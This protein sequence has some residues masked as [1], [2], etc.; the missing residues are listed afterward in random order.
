MDMEH[1]HEYVATLLVRVV[2]TLAHVLLR[3]P[4]EPPPPP[5]PP[6]PPS[7]PPEATVPIACAELPRDLIYAI[8]IQQPIDTRAGEVCQAWLEAARAFKLSL[9]L[10]A[11]GMYL[12]ECSGIRT[13]AAMCMPR[14]S[15]HAV[16]SHSSHIPLVSGNFHPTNANIE[17]FDF[18]CGQWRPFEEEGIASPPLTRLGPGQ[19]DNGS[20]P[21]SESYSAILGGELYVLS[22]H[23]RAGALLNDY[24][25]PFYAIMRVF[26]AGSGVLSF[27]S[28]ELDC[29]RSFS[30]P[31]VDTEPRLTPRGLASDG[32]STLY[33]LL[34]EETV[35]GQTPRWMAEEKLVLRTIDTRPTCLGGSTQRV[36]VVP[37]NSMAYQSFNGRLT[38]LYS[39]EQHAIV[40]VHE[41]HDSAMST[42]HPAQLATECPSI[43]IY[44][45]EQRSWTHATFPTDGEHLQKRV[46]IGIVSSIENRDYLV[47]VGGVGRFGLSSDDVTG[48]VALSRLLIESVAFDER[49]RLVHVFDL[50]A[51]AWTQGASLLHRRREAAVAGMGGMLWIVGG[52]GQNEEQVE[53]FTVDEDGKLVPRRLRNRSRPELGG[54]SELTLV[55]AR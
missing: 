29:S 15:A 27:V 46:G 5:P 11:A 52:A 19:E 7:P 16:P 53:C 38:M 20:N 9:R 25:R 22:I 2:S 12:G 4:I 36:A 24:I 35:D 8:V 41:T 21:P 28:A 48:A 39:Q 54:S 43:H 45:L 32:V 34:I 51:R 33:V 37:T 50:N 10:F 26:D 14:A 40:V 55:A 17:R 13:S 49:S 6:P 23:A 3:N 44:G 42:T 31:D 30:E 47:A 18:V 1:A